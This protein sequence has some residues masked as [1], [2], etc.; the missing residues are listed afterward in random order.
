MVTV[1]VLMTLPVRALP[2]FALAA[3][4][5]VTIAQVGCSAG[6]AGCPPGAR[7][8]YESTTYTRSDDLMLSDERLE[9]DRQR[10]QGATR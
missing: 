9:T 4:A 6:G 3:V 10:E 8:C 2:L 1:R 7:D 5:I